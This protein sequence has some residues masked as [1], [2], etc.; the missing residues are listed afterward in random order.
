MISLI[1]FV[2]IVILLYKII[3]FVN[4]RNNYFFDRNIPSPAIPS[5][6]SGHLSILW[7]TRSYS[8]QLYKWTK[9]LKSCTYG[10]FEGTR[11]LYVSSDVHFIQEVFT[12]QFNKFNSRRTTFFARLAGIER[13]H[14]V[15]AEG[16]Q[17]KRQRTVLNPT[18]SSVK[19]RS[20]VPTIDECA[21]IFIEQ[22]N[23]IDEHRSIN[24]CEMY[25]RFSMD[26]ICKLLLF[27]KYFQFI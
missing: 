10:L 22:L 24:I 8:E 11:P 7:S 12:K 15:I 20:L 19:M 1:L 18:F 2:L 23:K 27:E 21:S 17:W 6:I 9:E 4:Y 13:A 25:K 16:A 14:L 26:V 5:L 3:L